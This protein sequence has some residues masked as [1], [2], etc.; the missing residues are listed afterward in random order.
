MLLSNAIVKPN[1]RKQYQEQAEFTPPSYSA[2]ISGNFLKQLIEP[3]IALEKIAPLAGFHPQFSSFDDIYDAIKNVTEIS[4]LS[5][6]QKTGDGIASLLGFALNP[7]NIVLG[8]AGGLLAK[9]AVK[10]V[11]ALAPEFLSK[12]AGKTITKLSTETVGSLGE[13]AL[14][15]ASMGATSLLAQNLSESITSENKVNVS[16]LIK[17]SSIAGGFGLAL[18]VVPFAANVIRSKLFRRSETTLSETTTLNQA[19]KDKTITPEEEI[20]YQAYQKNPNDPELIQQ[21]SEILKKNH[22]D[23]VN[24]ID[25]KINVSLLTPNDIKALQSV[26]PDELLTREGLNYTDALSGFIQK[27][28]LDR[29]KQ[30]PD[31]SEGFKGIVIELENK[32]EKDWQAFLSQ[33][34]NAM[35][36]EPSADINTVKDYLKQRIEN[37]LPAAQL[38]EQRIADAKEQFKH[39]QENLKNEEIID[40]TSRSQPT[41]K[42]YQEFK[43]QSKVFQDL[44]HCLQRNV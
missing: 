39:Y 20:W 29:L 22:P 28:A 13:K 27:N 19:G 5:L 7:I 42:K 31:L 21:T 17:A 3:E 1:F 14:T 16:Q 26:I 23:T 15:G 32:G 12:L 38:T 24:P 36:R 25:N 6:T 43:T 4:G 30:H 44:I 8:G 34:I 2:S 11:S 35:N 40:E 10:G 41:F 18:G 33:L 9:G 37:Q